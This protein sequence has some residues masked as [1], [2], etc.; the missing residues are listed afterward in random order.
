MRW[1]VAR[2]PGLA[3]VLTVNR[4]AAL[5]LLPPCATTG[6][7]SL[8]LSLDEALQL[9]LQQ[10]VPYLPELVRVSPDHL[11]V[12]QALSPEL[13]AQLE[14]FTRSLASSPVKFAKAQLAGPVT[15]ARY[16]EPREGL[17]DHLAAKAA[18]ITRTLAVANVT[19]L[20][21]LDE[22]GLGDVP[23]DGLERVR[24]AASDAGAITG[25]HCC[26]QT[27]WSELLSMDFEVI[28]LDARLSLDALLD[29]RRA[30]LSFLERGGTL[31]LGIIPTEP[32]ARYDVAELCESVEASLR[33]TTPNFARALERMLLSPACGLGLRSPEDA[34]RISA[35]VRL[36][37]EQLRALL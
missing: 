17:V 37:Q 34:L 19:P 9:S 29:D 25:V 3:R 8:P 35:E 22:A 30:W 2:L 4:S 5:R 14:V 12:A 10:D 20:V 16:G 7:G 1:S 6:I 15:V 27:R 24:R 26:A 31:C 28:S 13:P 33:A 11:M 21:F 36:A 23:L 32:G 18:A